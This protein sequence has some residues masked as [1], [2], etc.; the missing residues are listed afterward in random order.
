MR[1]L[2]DVSTRLYLRQWASNAW[3]KRCYGREPVLAYLSGAVLFDLA[4]RLL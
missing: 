3:P 4:I 2:V 1:K